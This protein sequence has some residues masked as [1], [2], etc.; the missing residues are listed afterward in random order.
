MKINLFC[1]LC[2]FEFFDRDQY[3]SNEKWQKEND[4]TDEQDLIVG[5]YSTQVHTIML[6]T[7]NFTLRFRWELIVALCPTL[8]LIDVNCTHIQ[9]NRNVTLSQAF[10]CSFSNW[11]FTYWIW[12][13]NFNPLCMFFAT[14]MSKC[15]QATL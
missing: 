1:R 5:T 10:V 12:N 3:F 6:H 14:K 11:H 15:C 7:F 13:A 8:L 2:I 9:W 4:R